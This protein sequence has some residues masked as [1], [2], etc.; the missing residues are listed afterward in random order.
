[1]EP[2][3]P[4]TSD[5][6]PRHSSLVAAYR[7][8]TPRAPHHPHPSHRANSL[9]EPA[10]AVPHHQLN[11]PRSSGQRDVHNTAR[12]QGSRAG[13]HGS[14]A[15]AFR[16]FAS[17]GHGTAGEGLRSLERGEKASFPGDAL[18]MGPSAWRNPSD[19]GPSAWQNSAH[20]GPFAR[21]ISAPN[22]TRALQS[23]RLFFHGGRAVSADDADRYESSS[24]HFQ[25]SL[26]IFFL[27]LALERIFS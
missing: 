7:Q 15:Q 8:S 3:D 2:R 1:M 26:S 19:H 22:G 12:W 14:L 16:H 20:H 25:A 4:R 17:S 21:R 11:C 24:Y 10:L 13:S 5:A 18:G 9:H 27:P 23:G 6:V